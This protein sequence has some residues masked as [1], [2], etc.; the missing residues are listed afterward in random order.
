MA[1]RELATSVSTPEAVVV[2]AQGEHRFT[3]AAVDLGIKSNTPRLLAARG[4]E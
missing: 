3:V 1:G 2:P 4:I